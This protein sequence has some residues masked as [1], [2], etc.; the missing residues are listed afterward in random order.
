MDVNRLFILLVSVAVS[1]IF[2]QNIEAT[3]PLNL[4]YDLII[5]GQNDDA[6]LVDMQP[7]NATITK[8][9]LSS[10]TTTI[11]TTVDCAVWGNSV[12]LFQGM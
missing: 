8:I 11:S 9:A 2:C 10:F 6:Y 7:A 5:L 1:F 3:L 12:V 4:E